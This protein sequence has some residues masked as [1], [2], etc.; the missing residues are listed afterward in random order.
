MALPRPPPPY[1]KFLATGL[2]VRMPPP[3]S[4]SLKKA[5]AP[6]INQ[7]GPHQ[8]ER[9]PAINLRAGPLRAVVISLKLSSNAVNE[10][11][12]LRNC[13]TVIYLTIICPAIY[14]Q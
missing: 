6:S 12:H 3:R 11:N 5:L 7:R 4:K 2:T 10:V 8:S 14:I 9:P 1:E 13:S